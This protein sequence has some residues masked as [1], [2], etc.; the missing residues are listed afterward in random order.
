MTP[1]GFR[2]QY[3]NFTLVKKQVQTVAHTK[4]IMSV[5]PTK[6][7]VVFWFSVFLFVTPEHCQAQP[8]QHSNH[9]DAPA[10]YSW[11]W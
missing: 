10:K 8:T 4:I 3:Y 7:A 9:S 11:R 6:C 2:L 5:H 1:T